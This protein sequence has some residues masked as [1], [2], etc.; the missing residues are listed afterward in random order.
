VLA[1]ATHL[2]FAVFLPF[3]HAFSLDFQSF[4]RICE[5]VLKNTENFEEFP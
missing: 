2:G 5:K 4:W 3:S 1:G